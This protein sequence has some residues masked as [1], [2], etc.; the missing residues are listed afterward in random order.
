[1]LTRLRRWLMGSG[2]N[3]VTVVTDVRPVVE[4]GKIT[5]IKVARVQL[6]LP[7]GSLVG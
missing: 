4:G 5:G 7:P 3:A 1:M 6:Q 2:T